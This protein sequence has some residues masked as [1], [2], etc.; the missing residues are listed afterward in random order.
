[1]S[2]HEPSYEPSHASAQSV[3]VAQ[4]FVALS[5]ALVDDYDVVE[6]LDQ[7]VRHCVSLLEID[8]AAILLVG[9]DQSLE[10]MATSD[11][12]SR[13][14]ELV[15]L[16][17]RSGPCL[18]AVRTG[19]SL[20]VTD[21]EELRDRWPALGRAADDVGFRAIYAFPLRVRDQRIG[22]LNAFGDGGEPLAESDMRLA[23]ALA[24]VATVGI[25]QQ[26]SL[27]RVTELAEQLQ[28]ALDTRIAVEQ[29]KGVLAEYGGVD[30]P[31]AFEALRRYARQRR[32]KLGSVARAVVARE[33]AP[34]ELIPGRPRA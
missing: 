21:P 18:E 10:V 5:D 20:A 15:E 11:E 34:G 8:A 30:M 23:Q 25:L 12:A 29:A 1:M 17:S 22:A 9:S 6:L 28:Q 7:L 31:A 2:E 32:Q 27:S 26:R 24:D 19:E 13:L 33:L 4:S 3:R 14:M 16:Q